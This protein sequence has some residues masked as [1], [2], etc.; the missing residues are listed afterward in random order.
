MLDLTEEQKMLR[1]L[2]REFAQNELAPKAAEIDETLE[3]PIENLRKMGELG[4]LGIPFDEKY[5]GAGMDTLSFALAMEEFGA[6]CGSTALTVAAHTSLCCSPIYAFGTEAQKQKYL[7]DLL[8][9]KTLGAF[10]LTEPGSGSDSGGMQTRA[11]RDGDHYVL[12]GS[13]MF[14]TNAGYAGV[15]VL[16]AKTD[17]EKGTKGISAFIVEK[18]M[19]GFNVGKKEDKMGLRASDTRQIS[20]ENLRVPAENLLGEENH[21]FKI[22]L[23]TLDGGRVGIGA[24]SVGLARSAMEIAVRYAKE[25]YAF[26]RPIAQFQAIRWYIADMSTQIEAARLLVHQSARLRD[27]GKPYT[28]EA[29]MAKLFASEIAMKAATKSIQILGGYGY[30]RDYPV[31]RIFRDT[32]LMEIGEGTSEIQRLV[33]SREVLKEINA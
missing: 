17:I 8:S 15:C 21:G 30:I 25:R 31:E 13:K 10:G 5:G 9:G 1:Q 26:G 32:K 6:A 28:K 18:D 24:M 23:S 19:P 16:F 4:L 29:A 14:I 22:A 11:V 33:I 27:L 20:I 3:F 7:P 2:A 12:N